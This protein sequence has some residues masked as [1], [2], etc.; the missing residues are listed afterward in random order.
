MEQE[1]VPIGSS[2]GAAL[3]GSTGGN[4]PH[5]QEAKVGR[6]FKTQMGRTHEKG[7]RQRKQRLRA[8]GTLSRTFF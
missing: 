1:R 2:C 6:N 5:L 4:V 8:K 3:M 7:S